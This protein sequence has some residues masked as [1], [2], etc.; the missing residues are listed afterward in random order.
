MF[1][2]A[3]VNIM[4]HCILLLLCSEYCNWTRILWWL[5]L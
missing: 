4:L 5:W 1:G 3:T 2:V